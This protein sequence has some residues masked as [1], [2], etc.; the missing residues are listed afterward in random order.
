MEMT[1]AA[2]EQNA[3]LASD[4]ADLRIL[5][6]NQSTCLLAWDSA[7]AAAQK[8]RMEYEAAVA[9]GQRLQVTREVFRANSAGKLQAD[10]YRNMAFRIF[11]DDALQKYTAAF[12]LAARYVDLA[13]R[14]Y[15]YETALPVTTDTSLASRSL[16]AQVAR[17]RSLGRC[18]LVQET[19]NLPQPLAGG[20]TGD[21]GLAD[22]MARLQANWSVL[23]S[24]YG[25]NNPQ[26][27]TGRF[28]LRAELFRIPPG[29]NGDAA[30]RDELSRSAY[31]VTNLMEMPE[32]KYYCLPFDPAGAAEPAL[33]IPFH[34]TIEFGKNF[35]GKDLASGDNAYDSSRFATKI[36][37]VGVWFNNFTNAFNLSTTSGGGLANTPRVYL[38]PVGMDMM[39]IPSVDN[40][41]V[42]TW[43]V[44]DQALP[45]PFPLTSYDLMNP[46]WIPLQDSQDGS[47]ATLR[48]Y[49]ALRAYHDAGNFNS[50]EVTGDSRLVGRSVWNSQW[51]LI[52][53][54]GALLSDGR[55]GI[56][57]FIH[58]NE[59]STGVWD[60]NGVKDILIFFQT[61][62]YAGN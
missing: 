35:F 10:R 47:F 59:T 22:I 8:A 45:V 17:A 54:G 27:E 18:S 4:L 19:Y 37:S 48:K 21:P 9:E 30:W 52:I 61:Y 33:V 7:L 36:R 38:I 43:T 40:K 55:Q 31:Q 6:N 14:A 57:R 32:F 50:S 49:P 39:R 13:V 34:T 16:S 2:D 60:E 12:D 41:T 25:F 23:K 53:P 28:S 46:N 1:I 26:T 44:F 51:L 11:R 42:R 56:Q 62:S 29:T 24:R 5:M 15:D 3:E 58:G 20:P